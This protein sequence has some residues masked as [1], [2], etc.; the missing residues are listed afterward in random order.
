MPR[1]SSIPAEVLR[2]RYAQYHF[3]TL[4]YPASS[5]GVTLPLGHTRCPKL[6]PGPMNKIVTSVRALPCESAIF[7]TILSVRWRAQQFRV[8]GPG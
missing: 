4:A 3:S 1:D 7:Y 8:M 5:G 6:H 2:S